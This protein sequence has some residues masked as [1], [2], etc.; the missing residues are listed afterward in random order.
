MLDIVPWLTSYTDFFP[1]AAFFALILAGLNVPISEDLI[2]ITGALVCR[3]KPAMLI[4]VY[5]TMYT[6]VIV[7]DFFNYWLGKMIKKGARK[8]R[9]LTWLFTPKNM[10]KMHG[11]LEKYGIFTFIICR[12]IPFGVRNTLF[13][14]SGFFDLKLK[15][16]ILYDIPAATVSVST[17]F[18]L[19][20]LFGDV[21]ENVFYVI[22]IVFYIMVISSVVLITI[23]IIR[24]IVRKRKEALDKQPDC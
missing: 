20:Y 22:G 12:F 3:G 18:I 7:G 17:L 14:T 19:A 8:L 13:M 16:F 15:R 2:I 4:P 11:Y 1:V 9:F 10:D 5:I 21:F 24:N 6:G 23:R